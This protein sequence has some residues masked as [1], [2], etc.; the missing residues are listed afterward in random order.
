M[1]DVGGKDRFTGVAEAGALPDWWFDR[2]AE[3][4]RRQAARMRELGITTILRGFEVNVPGQLQQLYPTANISDLGGSWALDALDPLYRNLSDAYMTA[5]IEE[6][7]TDHFYQADGFFNAAKGPWL[8]GE[9]DPRTPRE[10]CRF[11]LAL[12]LTY[13]RGCAPKNDYH[14]AKYDT[15]SRGCISPQ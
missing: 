13:I 12:N 7:G 6:F 15:L 11:S 14:C 1:A 8:R 5:L 2:Q 3:L 4:G 9:G 10:A